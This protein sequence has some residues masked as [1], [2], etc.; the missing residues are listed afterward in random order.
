MARRATSLKIRRCRDRD[1][2]A[3]PLGKAERPAQR[4]HAAKAAAQH[5]RELPDAEGVEQA[6]LRI[7]PVFNGDDRKIGAVWLAGRR[8]RLHGAGRPEA[9]PGVV[10]A[11]HEEA[12]GVERLARADEV[13]PPA[14]ALGLSGVGAGHMVARVQR[15]AHQHRIA[16]VGVQRAVGLERERVVAQ[17]RAAAQGERCREVKELR[18][19]FADRLR[20]NQEDTL[21]KQ[22][23]RRRC[24]G[25]HR[26]GV[27]L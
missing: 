21:R 12:V 23:T 11:D 7:D 14:F 24:K 3:Q 19:D 6:R 15:V 22:K 9:R 8:V 17:L 16:A 27:P 4:L 2:M 26:A 10:D 18:L 1:A 5:C 25:G 20:E 13:V